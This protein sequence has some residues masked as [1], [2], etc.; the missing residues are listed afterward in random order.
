M[1]CLLITLNKCLWGHKSLESLCSAVKT[2]IVSGA[3]PRDRQWVLLSC[4]GQLKKEKRRS[5]CSPGIRLV[6]GNAMGMVG[7]KSKCW[8]VP[9]V[10]GRISTFH[11][12]RLAIRVG[13]LINCSFNP[14]LGISLQFAFFRLTN[15]KSSEKNQPLLS[16][17]ST[18]ENLIV[19][20]FAQCLIYFHHWRDFSAPFPIK[21]RVECNSSKDPSPQ[22]PTK[23]TNCTSQLHW[24]YQAYPVPNFSWLQ[25]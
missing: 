25:Q 23:S 6:S 12:E 4:C 14:N 5:L 3:Q 10:S 7:M 18:W 8:R 1:S 15:L 9:S 22:Q 2:L 24:R 17:F 11:I 16:S 20:E 19:K 13:I 21:A